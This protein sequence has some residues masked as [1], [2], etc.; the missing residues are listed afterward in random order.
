MWD[1]IESNR[2]FGF[3]E[4][5]ITKGIISIFV[6]VDWPSPDDYRKCY[7]Y[8]YYYM[9]VKRNTI[10]TICDYGVMLIPQINPIFVRLALSLQLQIHLQKEEKW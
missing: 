5:K 8:F 7:T 6:L 4:F 1:A 10:N 2:N 3:N 9:Y